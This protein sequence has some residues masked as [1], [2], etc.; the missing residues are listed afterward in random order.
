MPSNRLIYSSLLIGLL[1]STT[2]LGCQTTGLSNSNKSATVD[3][4]INTDHVPLAPIPIPVQQIQ[5]QEPVVTEANI[6]QWA[7]G[8]N[9]QL[10]Q[11]L[12]PQDNTIAIDNYATVQL[13]VAPSSVNFYQ[14]CQ[15]FIIKFIWMSTPPFPYG[16]TEINELPSTCTDNKNN[17][18]KISGGSIQTLFPKNSS[19]K[20][21]IA[22]LPLANNASISTQTAPKKLAIKV[23]NGNTLIFEGTP[24]VLKKPTGLPIDNAL[25]ERYQWRLVSAVSNIFDD[26]GTIVSRTPIGDFYHPDFPVSL[27]FLSH[28]DGQYAFFSSS[29]NGVGGPYILTRDNTLLV[30]SGPQTMM[31]CGLN[32]N[33]IE[34]TLAKITTRSRSTLNLSLQPP[35]LASE[36]ANHSDFP[37]YN[38]LQTM[39]TGETLVWQNEEKK[40][41][42]H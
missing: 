22:L 29:C 28:S 38:L 10:K 34:G 36:S 4:N 7:S 19:M 18:N 5:K 8:Y 24:K 13:E 16:T 15:R 23:E 21:N 14:G 17:D 41:P 37:Y 35:K 39:E 6:I 42:E 30:G 32:G 27:I 3:S 1:T 33:R 11:A 31:G 12:N 20:L 40:N 26:N 25:L 2:L 9:W